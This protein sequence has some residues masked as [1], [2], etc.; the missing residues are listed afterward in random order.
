MNKELPPDIE[1]MV[2]EDGVYIEIT[3]FIKFLRSDDM[4]DEYRS[5][6]LHLKKIADYI[7]SHYE[8]AILQKSLLTEEFDRSKPN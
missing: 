3:G 8:D 5:E 1:I 6:I 4:S 2:T 7:E